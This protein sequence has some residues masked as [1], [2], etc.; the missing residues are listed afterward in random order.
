MP[1]AALIVALAVITAGVAHA[2]HGQELLRKYDCYICHADTETRTGPAYADV[3]A[4]YRGD[5]KAVATLIAL[6]KKGAH[7][8]SPWHMPPMP[9]VPDAAARQMVDYIL[10]QKP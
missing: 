2:Q 9:Q 3:A 4:K 5:P 8:S 7:G 1:R 6:V 10:S